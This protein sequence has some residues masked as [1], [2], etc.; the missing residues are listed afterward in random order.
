MVIQIQIWEFNATKVGFSGALDISELFVGGEDFT[1][2]R[3]EIFLT[4]LPL[5][6]IS[7]I[8]QSCDYI[9]HI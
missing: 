1:I 8:F 6:M 4:V 5:L 7:V 9:L 3:F 2:N